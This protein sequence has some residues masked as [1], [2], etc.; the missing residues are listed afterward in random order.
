MTEQKMT[1]DRLL[2]VGASKLLLCGEMMQQMRN[3]Q[4]DGVD[5]RYWRMSTQL[6]EHLIVA[7]SCL[8]ESHR[9]LL[10][11]AVHAVTAAEGRQTK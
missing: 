4:R 3:L 5:Q 6:S 8:A 11:Q 1:V 9:M 10:E 2:A 7:G